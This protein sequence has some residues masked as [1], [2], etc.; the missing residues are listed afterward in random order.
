MSNSTTLLETVEVAQAAK[1]TTV[2]QLFDAHSPSSIFGRHA[3]ACSGLTW[4]YYGGSIAV[5]GVLTAV[6]NGTVSLTASLSNFVERT[7]AGVVSANT[8]GFTAG[9][10]PLYLVVCGGSSVT[11]YTDY[12]QCA[13]EIGV[14]GRLSLSVAGN[15][16]VTLTAAQARNHIL[17]FSGALTGNIN[18]IVPNGPQCW[19]VTNNTSGAYTLT[20]KTTAGSGVVVSQGSAGL[21]SADGTNVI[22]IGYDADLATIAG[23]TA[24]TDN[25]IQAKSSAWASRTPAQVAVDLQGAGLDVD[26]AGFRGVPIN[27][28]S[29]NYTTVAADAGK[30]LLH[31][32]GGGSGDTFTIDSNANVAYEVGTAITFCNMDS[33]GLSIAITSDTLN[34]AGAGTTGTRTLAQYGIATALKVTSTGWLISGTGLT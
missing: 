25:F 30:M 33:N 7:R 34:L 13:L 27:S 24:T 32:S 9:R 31:P 6:A 4:G 18:V 14:E 2:N 16:D 15:T 20:V 29:A 19:A 17:N 1:E 23:L 21:L 11:S 8:S 10:V 3:E 12:R 26:M 22:G 28:Q 5:D